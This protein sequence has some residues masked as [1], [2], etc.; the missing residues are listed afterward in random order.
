MTIA[1][2]HFCF[3]KFI[4]ITTNVVTKNVMTNQKSVTN[5]FNHFCEF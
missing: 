3:K 1:F 4:F 5:V 2:N